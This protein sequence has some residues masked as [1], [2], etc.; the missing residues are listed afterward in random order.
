MANIYTYSVYTTGD[1]QVMNGGTDFIVPNAAP[2]LQL[3][4]VDT[5]S[6]LTTN[7]PTTTRGYLFNP[8]SGLYTTNGLIDLQAVST[9]TVDS[10]GGTQ[11]ITLYSVT[12]DVGGTV[13]SYH[14]ISTADQ[15]AFGNEQVSFSTISTAPIDYT[16]IP[17]WD[18]TLTG[19]AGGPNLSGGDSISGLD[20]DD[21]LRGLSGNDTITG[22]NGDDSIDGAVGN[23]SIVGGAGADSLLGGENDDFVSGGDGDD[24]VYGDGSDVRDP[25]QDA[26]NFTFNRA[27]VTSPE[28]DG[29]AGNEAVGDSVT[30]QAVAT[31]ADGVVV[32]ARFTIVSITNGD[33]TQASAMPVDLNNANTSDPNIVI[34]NVGATAVNGPGAVY[35][36]HKATI[37]VEFFAANGPNAG[38]PIQLN[39]TFVFRDLDDTDPTNAASVPDKERLTVQTSEFTSYTVSDPTSVAI[40]ASDPNSFTFSGTRNNNQAA[41]TALEQEQNQVALDFVNRESFTVTL[42]SRRVN[43]GFSFDTREFSSATVT[44]DASNEGNDTVLGGA[45]NDTLY[46][47]SGND[48]LD[49][50]IGNDLID[51]GNDADIIRLNDGFGADTI[52]GAEGGVDQDTLTAIGLTTNGVDVIITEFLNGNL[53]GTA[54]EVTTSDITEFSEIETIVLSNNDDSFDSTAVGAITV[55]GLQG[56]DS[57]STGSGNDTIYGG[58]SNTSTAGST[59]SGNDTISSGAGDDFVFAGDGDDLVIVGG[60]NDSIRGQAGNDTFQLTDNFGRDTIRGDGGSDLIDASQLT[61]HGIDVVFTNSAGTSGSL[62]DQQGNGN[63]QFTTTEQFIY[64]EQGDSVN[65]SAVAADGKTYDLAGGDDTF[66]A[67]GS[68]GSVTVVGGAGDDSITGSND[69]DDLN[70]GAGDDTIFGGAGND[71]LSGGDGEDVITLQEGDTATGGLNDDLFN[72]APGASTTGGNDPILIFGG[73]DPGDVDIDALALAGLTNASGN[74]LTRNDITFVQGDPEAGSFT[75]E[76]GTVVTFSQIERVICF[77]ALAR[78]MTPTGPRPAGRLKVGDLVVTRDHGLQPIRWIGRKTTAAT[79]ALAPIQF[80][81]GAMGNR[82]ALRVS[83]QH[84]MLVRD[85]ALRLTHGVEEMLVAAKHMVNG[86]TIRQISDGS[87]EYVHLMFDRHAIIFAEGI[88]SESFHPGEMGY[89]ALDPAGRS[90]LFSLFPELA[91]SGPQSYGPASRGTLKPWELPVR[92][93]QTA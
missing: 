88:E 3:H 57:I 92:F 6:T 55:E 2:E 79:G 41:L 9:W 66:S 71:T 52:R 63:G 61:A 89:E 29:G 31:T 42:T 86:N 18:E 33:G 13:T 37:I 22:G 7:E 43:S 58:S 35:G 84:R 28:G 48:D 50:G 56:D 11:S 78:I 45:G 72:F 16:A 64:S 38:Q 67:A 85:S 87:I 74:Q 24:I 5:N 10:T 17:S 47:S 83:P 90:E 73:E 68:N 81:A 80:D 30:Y 26:A 60:G 53:T 46:G 49:G 93:A 54:Q 65:T 82:N 70:G 51:A 12:L 69:G 76:D 36:G 77:D 39:G 15:A 27:N 19:A 59:N 44:G 40:D 8:A 62:G 25:G 34:L 4:I 91:V 14:M 21:S 23:D 1:L 75:M 20:G 32:D